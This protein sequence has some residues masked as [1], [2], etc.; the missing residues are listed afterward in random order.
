MI[1]AICYLLTYIFEALI[2]L[3]CFSEKFDI[4]ASKKMVFWSFTISAFLQFALSFLEMPF[5]NLGAFLVFNILL[6]FLLFDTSIFQSIFNSAILTATMVITELCIYYSSTLLFG[7]EILEATVND[8]V[9]WIQ[10]ACTK[11]LYFFVALLIAKL[12]RKE[13]RKTF[14]SSKEAFLFI[15]PL[16]SIVLLHGILTITIII[17]V[18][19]TVY[20]IFMVSTILLIYSNIIIFWIHESM[21]KTQQEITEYRLQTQKAEIDTE[22]Y[23]LLQNHYESSNILIHDI[24]RHLMSIKEYANHNDCTSINKYIDDLY[25]EYQIKHLRKYSTHKLVNAIINRYVSVCK[26][27]G[28]DLYCDVRD[29]DFSFINDA[30]LTSILDNLLENAVEAS[31]NSKDKTIDLTIK[32]NHSNFVVIHLENSCATAP[33]KSGGELKTTKSNKDIHGFGIR[34]IKRIAKEYDGYIEYSF[35]EN[36][37]IFTFTVV[38]NR[39]K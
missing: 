24:K 3:M 15:L 39:S 13:S 7:T 28:I 9:L 26:N 12:S 31:K 22:Y 18:P 33:K 29:I 38:L 10:T 25:G 30:N 4:K 27:Y 19:K 35:D 11:L 21:L 8:T 36:S 23:S 34:S 2:S 16:A 17:D 20:F 14:R 32:E 37:M 1:S 5:I 6:C